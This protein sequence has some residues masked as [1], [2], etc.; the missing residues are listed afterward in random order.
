MNVSLNVS[1][2]KDVNLLKRE[3]IREFSNRMEAYFK[4]KTY[5][6]SIETYA[7]GMNCVSPEFASFFKAEKPSYTEDKNV[8]VYGIK[9]HLYKS[10][11]FCLVLNYNDF[12]KS[13]TGDGLK[14]M[15]SEIMKALSEIKYPKKI[16]DFDQ[17]IFYQDMEQF[18]KEQNLI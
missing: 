1:L 10:F 11:G 7:I 16:K 18:F 2:S 9:A 3:E 8:I 13:S 12:K 15:A 4:N 14:I 6:E 17:E 5:G